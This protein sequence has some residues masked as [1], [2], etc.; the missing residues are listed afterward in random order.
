[1]MHVMFDVCSTQKELRR[2]VKSVEGCECSDT[3]R[4]HDALSREEFQEEKVR[5]ARMNPDAVS[6]T[7]TKSTPSFLR[8]QI[9]P[10][11]PGSLLF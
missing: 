4:T 3:K 11:V 8:K 7:H 2:S 6:V 5:R 9:L 1:M 10:T